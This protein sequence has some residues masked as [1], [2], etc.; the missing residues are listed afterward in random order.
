MIRLII[1]CFLLGSGWCRTA[2][3]ENRFPRPEFDTAYVQPVTTTPA[4]RALALQHLDV[5]VL[6]VTLTLA[7]A[8][9]VRWRSRRGL[10]LLTLFSLLYFGFWRQGCVCAVGATQNIVLAFADHSYA[11]P[12]TVVAFFALPLLF[13]LFFGR[14]FCAAVCPLGAMQDVVILKPLRLPRWLSHLLGL[15][16]F[17]YLALALLFAA[18][19]GMFVICRYDPFVGFFRLSAPASMLWFGG[20][21]LVLGTVIARPYCR[22]LCPYGALLKAASWV[23]KWHLAITP[24]A[25]VDCRLCRPACPFD[26]IRWPSSPR[27]VRSHQSDVR[28]FAIFLVA[29]PLAVA[30]GAWTGLR[31]APAL[32]TSLPEIRLA[33]AMTA[34]P[35]GRPAVLAVETDAFLETGEPLPALFARAAATEHRFAMGSAITGGF[36]AA[37]IVLKLLSL[38]TRRKLAAHV[39]DRAECLSCGRCMD[40]CPVGLLCIKER[41]EGLPRSELIAPAAVD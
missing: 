24:D 41:V 33:R 7:A 17:A 16:P 28:R 13:A 11:I 39:P 35:A 3:A 12:V 1:L 30:L 40:A 26:A 32:A 2:A 38:S 23:S 21:L 36:L 31:L 4:P 15:L 37:I 20:I 29:L 9:A 18:T 27:P 25:C 14:V 8:F 6:A 22:F 19:G 34:P 5:V 10:R